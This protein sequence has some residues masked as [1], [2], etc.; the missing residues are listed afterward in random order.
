MLEDPRVPPRLIV[1]NLI[2]NFLVPL[3]GRLSQWACINF[4]PCKQIGRYGRSHSLNISTIFPGGSGVKHPP[5][6]ALIARDASSPSGPRVPSGGIADSE[7]V[8]L[9]LPSDQIA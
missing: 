2:I 5:R 1:P 3:R 4:C 9:Q 6:P 7:C 8:G